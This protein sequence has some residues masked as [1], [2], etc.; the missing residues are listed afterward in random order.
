MSLQASL[1]KLKD[2]F[3][4]HDDNFAIVFGAMGVNMETARWVSRFVVFLGLCLSDDILLVVQRGTRGGG[5][6]WGG[7]GF[8][9]LSTPLGNPLPCLV[10]KS[11]AQSP[12][13][14]HITCSCLAR[15]VRNTLVSSN[16]PSQSVYGWASCPCYRSKF[17]DISRPGHWCFRLEMA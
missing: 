5:R 4:S 1:V 12:H 17:F 9:Q 16:S 14:P 3:D 8:V 7:G 13:V 10:Q 2:V 15:S 6:N 11:V